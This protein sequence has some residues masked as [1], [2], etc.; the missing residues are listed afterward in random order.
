MILRPAVYKHGGRIISW[1]D[2]SGRGVIDSEGAPR[3][4]L[5]F[6]DDLTVDGFTVGGR[7]LF[8]GSP[9]P[10]SSERYPHAESVE[11]IG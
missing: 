8:S 2:A 7:V 6:R 11:V 4:W 9:D 3:T 5:F 1:D 10:A